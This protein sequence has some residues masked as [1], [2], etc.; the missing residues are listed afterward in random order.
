MTKQRI[1]TYP[2]ML[3]QP[4]LWCAFICLL[5]LSLAACGTG[6]S[7]GSGGSGSSPT[8]TATTPPTPTATPIPFRVSQVDLVV[9]PNSIAGKLCGSS[10]SFTYSATFHIPAGTAG[11]TIQFL[12]SVNN[13]RSSPSASVAVSAGQTTATYSFTTSGTLYP[14]HTYPGIAQVQVTSPNAVNSPQ[15]KPAGTCVVGAAFKVTSIA[16][17]VSPISLTGLSCGTTIT[18]TY[19]ATFHIMPNSPGGTIQFVYTW[20]NGR[21]SP[22]A[23]VPASAGQTTA[24]YAFTWSGQLSADHVLPGLGGV[25]A[26]SPNTINSPLVKP[27]GGCA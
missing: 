14:D 11:G 12:Y 7:G 23:S 2:V 1:H 6:G 9:S 18:V 5:G 3:K 27:A 20:N 21:G 16:M 15:I 13:G 19:T 24:T 26:S 25:I 4:F 10:L 22:N 8:P 17:A